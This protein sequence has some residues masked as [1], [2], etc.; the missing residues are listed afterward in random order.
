MNRLMTSLKTRLTHFFLY[1]FL[2]LIACVVLLPFLIML[3]GSFREH[4]DIIIRGPLA[5]PKIWHIENYENVLFKYRFGIFFRNTF[6]I[7]TPTVIISLIFAVMSAYSLVFLKLFFRNIMVLLSTVLGVMIA[8]EF[9]MIPLYKLMSE[10]NLLDTYTAAIIPQLAMSAAFSTLIIRSFFLGLPR[11]LLD[12]A[13]VD[14]AAN[15]RILWTILVPIAKPAIITSGALTTVW[16]WNSYIVPLVLI[17]NPSKVPLAVGLLLFQGT[18][19][20]NIPLT[21][22]GTVV[23]A[24]PMLLFYL[25]FQRHII[26]GLTQGA[27]D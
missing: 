13:R 15:W 6:Y 14:G 20:I 9:I 24:L 7:T 3:L 25:F 21:M 27:V 18:Y 11:D 8:S 23:T 19:T 22:T 4:I 26:R 16:T 12:A 10:L 5:L 2:I 1:I 17:S